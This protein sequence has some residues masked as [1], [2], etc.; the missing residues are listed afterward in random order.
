MVESLELSWAELQIT[1][2]DMEVSTLACILLG[3]GGNST[4]RIQCEFFNLFLYD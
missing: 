1:T 4:V 3:G 2:R